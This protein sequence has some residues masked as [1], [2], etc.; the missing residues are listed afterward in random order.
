MKRLSL[1][2]R[3]GAALLITG[4]LATSCIM[5]WAPIIVY[6]QVRDSA[7]NDLLNP[8]NEHF[9]GEKI[10][11]TFEGEEYPMQIPT[12]YYMPMFSG[13]ELVSR[14]DFD[15]WCLTFGE[16]DGSENRNDTFTL[17]WPDG[18][19]DQITFHRTILTPLIVHDAWRLNGK[20]TDLPI[21]IEK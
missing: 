4:I 9:L 17:T 14:K 12:K 10:T 1:A 11:M 3:L 21:L 8:G 13:L 16:L 15:G 5:D 20:K 19:K 18:S 7:G 6:V 2:G